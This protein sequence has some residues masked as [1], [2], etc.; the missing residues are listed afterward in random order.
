MDELRLLGNDAAHI[1]AKSFAQI[2]KPE[3]DVAIEFTI[4]LLKALY[5]YASLLGKMRGL[6]KPAAP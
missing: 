6:K 2:S 5:Q 4:E 1:E 3:I